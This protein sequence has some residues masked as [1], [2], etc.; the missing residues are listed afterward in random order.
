MPYQ[1]LYTH[2]ARLYIFSLWLKIIKL[3]AIYCKINYLSKELFKAT[4]RLLMDCLISGMMLMSICLQQ[5]DLTERLI[6][7]LS[8]LLS[9]IYFLLSTFY[10]L[11]Y[12]LLFVISGLRSKC[13]YFFFIIL[14]SFKLPVLYG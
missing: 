11:F 1:M 8:V 7:L 14:K 6:V 2:C 5:R 10:F 3:L 9:T 4:Y 13:T 12:F